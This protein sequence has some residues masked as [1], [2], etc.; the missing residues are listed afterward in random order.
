MKI[1]FIQIHVPCGGVLLFLL[2]SN[3]ETVS[4]TY[5]VQRPTKNSF[6]QNT[7]EY[8]QYSH[9]RMANRQEWL[10]SHFR[11]IRL[12]WHWSCESCKEL[13]N[14][15]PEFEFGVRNDYVAFQRTKLLGENSDHMVILCESKR[16]NTVHRKHDGNSVCWFALFAVIPSLSTNI[17]NYLLAFN[18]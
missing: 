3:N 1:V 11:V 9:T 18:W 5:Y 6:H 15:K 8:L 16:Y 4:G 14:T 10:T 13:H 2:A 7:L 12:R 17:F